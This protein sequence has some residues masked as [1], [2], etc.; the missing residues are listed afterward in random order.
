MLKGSQ[1]K[2]TKYKIKDVR[3]GSIEVIIAGASLVT[4]ILMPLIQIKIQ[5]FYKKQEKPPIKFE[6]NKGNKFVSDALDKYENSLQ[7]SGED[8][9]GSL[10]KYLSE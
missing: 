7:N 10:I 4:S 5:E 3:N 2:Q 6:F 9:Q 8:Y 1:I